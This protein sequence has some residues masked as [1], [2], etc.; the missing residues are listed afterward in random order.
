M[1]LE[2]LDRLTPDKAR[3]TATQILEIVYGLVEKMRVVMDGEQTDLACHPP[4]IDF[5]YL[6]TARHRSTVSRMPW[7]CLLV[8]MN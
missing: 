8:T 5:S 4:S 2:R 7:V 1:A 6:Q 3:K